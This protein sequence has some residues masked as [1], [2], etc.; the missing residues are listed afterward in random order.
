MSESEFTQALVNEWR[1]GHEDMK[2]IR[3]DELKCLQD[4]SER[5]KIHH[6]EEE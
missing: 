6:I 3:C 5:G 1:S 4:D 2:T